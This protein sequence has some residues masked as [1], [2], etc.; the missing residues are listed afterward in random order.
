MSGVADEAVPTPLD[1]GDGLTGQNRKVGISRCKRHPSTA[2]S[3]LVTWWRLDHMRSRSTSWRRGSAP[4]TEQAAPGSSTCTLSSAP[5]DWQSESTVVPGI[6][7]AVRRTSRRL[8]RSTLT[9]RSTCRSETPPT[10]AERPRQ[11]RH[12]TRS[13]PANQ[14]PRMKCCP[15]VTRQGQRVV[16][17]RSSLRSQ[18]GSSC[19][20]GSVEPK[21]RKHLGETA[22]LAEA[23]ALR[24]PNRVTRQRPSPPKALR[25]PRFRSGQCTRGH[26]AST[27]AR[28]LHRSRAT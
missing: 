17:A 11:P 19:L 1:P 2:R 27:C 4:T 14:S 24:V 15:C 25:R 3:I 21:D 5:F 9:D 28:T 7:D 23:D 16:S 26:S 18:C 13:R 20:L 10:P 22:L 6:R 8:M 12:P